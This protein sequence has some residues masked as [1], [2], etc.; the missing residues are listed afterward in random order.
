M[1]LGGKAD[2]IPKI[3]TMQ[4]LHFHSNFN[5]TFVSGLTGL[6]C[7]L[8]QTFLSLLSFLGRIL[9]PADQG[10]AEL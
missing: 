4:F 6:E 10:P 5:I 9:R 2:C 1:P 7:K 3:K 8:R